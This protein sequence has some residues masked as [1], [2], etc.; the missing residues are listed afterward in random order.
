[1]KKITILALHLG[2]GGIERAVTTLANSLVKDYEIEIISTYKLYEKSFF[3]LNKKVKVQYLIDYGPNK[4]EMR[5]ALQ[6]KKLF[7]FLYE[8]LK[9]LHILNLRKKRMI[10][11]I[12]NCNSDIILSTRDIHN[13]WLSKYGKKEAYKIGWEH[14]HH[15]NNSKYIKKIVK[16]AKNL[17]AFVLVSKELYT[18]YKKQLKEEKC[19]TFYIPNFI[20]KVTE[21]SSPLTKRNLITVGRLSKEK[22]HLDLIEVIHLLQN[23]RE[24]FHLTIIGDGNEREKIEKEIQKYNLQKKVT[25][26]GYQKKEKVEKHLLASSLF[27]LPSYKE[28]FGLVVLESFEKGVPVICFDTA[29]GACEIITNKEDGFIIKNR[30][31]KE[32]AKK[33]DFLLKDT[34]KRKTMGK[35]AK[36]K[37][38]QYEAK[39]V[40]KKWVDLFE[41]RK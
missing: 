13:T 33:I 3:S 12:K 15:N 41:K 5:E 19:K 11:C 7:S 16:S 4:K 40:K 32:M 9:A 23:K 21:E 29:K 28:S 10:K 39:N 17:D 31:K 35:K 25:L 8:F 27:L 2:Y 22:G 20:E 18:F 30:N 6:K 38:K 26:L 1:M 37:A 14:N 34:K 36:E 24:D